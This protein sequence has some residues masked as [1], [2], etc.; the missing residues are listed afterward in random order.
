MPYRISTATAQAAPA[1]SAVG[2]NP[3]EFGPWHRRPRRLPS[4]VQYT[5]G[6]VSPNEGTPA[7]GQS[8]PEQG[9]RG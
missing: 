1:G 5:D 7:I 2:K 8:E 4:I 3:R 6:A 9:A